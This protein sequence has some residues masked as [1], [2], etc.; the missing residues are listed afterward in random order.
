M[1]AIYY[2]AYGAADVLRYGDQPTPVAQA[3]QV[4]VRVRA[5]SVNPV[6]WKVRARAGVLDLVRGAH[7]PKIPGCDLAGEVVAV[8]ANMT[9]FG[10]GARVFGLPS[11]GPGVGP[12]TGRTNAEFVAASAD[13][14]AL[15]PD[16][17]SFV[18]AAA[19]PLGALTALQGLRNHGRLLSGDR[20]LVTGAAGG[21]GSLA[22]Q[23]ARLLGAGEVT[24]VCSPQ[25]QELV[26]SL[27]A[28][29]VLDRTT[30]DFTRER[31]RYDLVFDAAGKSSFGAS[32]ASLRDRGRYITIVPDPPAIAKGL[33]AAAFSSKKFRTFI[34]WPTGPDMALVAA[35]LQTG[36]LRP[37]PGRTFPLAETAAAHRYG[38]A[39]G[40]TGR[41]V[42]VME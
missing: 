4:L 25:H 19:V 38:E 12:G 15:I 5:S 20:V 13:G 22:V 7:F 1:K 27:G 2:E 41:M 34:A 21:V 39:G 24:G 35:W 32:A 26:R 31:S 33:L 6:D 8:G 29:R 3:D 10:V 23:V 40:G 28:D 9:R 17:L 11:G 30:H 16:Q 42:L 36:A 14:L 37:V 18:Q